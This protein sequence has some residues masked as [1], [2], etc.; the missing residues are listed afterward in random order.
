MLGGW[1]ILLLLSIVA[2]YADKLPVGERATTGEARGAASASDG[3]SLRLDGKRIRIEGIDAPELDQ[4]CE[5]DGETWDCGRQ[6]RERLR[7]LIQAE[8]ARA[9]KERRGI[10]VGTFTTPQEWRRTNDHPD[11]GPHLVDGWLETIRRWLLERLTALFAGI[12]NA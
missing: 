3:D 1:I 12:G 2:Y 4:S 6:A 5:R 7:A 10:W 9:E 11:E 8:E